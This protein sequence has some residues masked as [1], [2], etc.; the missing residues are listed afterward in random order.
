MKK[1]FI[2]DA[3]GYVNNRGRSK[4]WGV[5]VD[6]NGG[7]ILSY[8]P[9]DDD[10]THTASSVGF[11]ISEIDLARIAAKI[12]E[13]GSKRKF[14]ESK[15][16]V[17]SQDKQWVYTIKQN[18]IYREAYRNQS[19]TPSAGNV[20]LFDVVPEQKPSA[21]VRTNKAPDVERQVIMSEREYIAKILTMIL[22][23][24][25]SEPTM[26]ELIQ[27]LESQIK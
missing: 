5:T 15:L 8:F 27:I 9:N 20:S 7:W 4:Y 18:S 10:I 25:L 14:T 19:I 11:R 23:V 12:Y 6:T 1:P 2:R 13:N 3:H 21:P 24:N 26:R 17:L 22:D 16:R